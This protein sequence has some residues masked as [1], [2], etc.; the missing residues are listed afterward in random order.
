V[1][2]ACGTVAC[3]D[4]DY[5]RRGEERGISTASREAKGAT[6]GSVEQVVGGGALCEHGKRTKMMSG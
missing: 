4:A 3:G 1:G 6:Q 5:G 2:Q